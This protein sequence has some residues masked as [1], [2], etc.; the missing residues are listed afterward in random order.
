VQ[1]SEFELDPACREQRR[2]SRSDPDF[3]SPSLCLLSLGEARE[4]ES[5][6]GARPGKG[7]EVDNAG[8]KADLDKFSS[9]SQWASRFTCRIQ[10]INFTILVTRF[11]I[12]V[13]LALATV[14]V[15]ELIAGEFLLTWYMNHY[16]I[17]VRAELSEDYGLGML[18]LLKSVIVFAIAFPVAAYFCWRWVGVLVRRLGFK[19]T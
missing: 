7:G 15:G 16:G 6:A 14:L 18:T 19:A 3:G 5:P 13:F 12:T 11:L 8:G 17:S 10:M 2:G 1:R 4:S 9:P